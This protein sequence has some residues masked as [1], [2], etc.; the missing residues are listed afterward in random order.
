M[1]AAKAS[2]MG[3]ASAGSR[4]SSAATARSVRAS[5]SGAISPPPV[6]V[7]PEAGACSGSPLPVGERSAAVSLSGS[8]LPLGEGAASGA[9]RVASPVVRARVRWDKALD[10]PG[11]G[12]VGFAAAAVGREAQHAFILAMRFLEVEVLGDARLEHVSLV[13]LL[14]HA[15][16]VARR[17][18]LLVEGGDH[19]R[20][21][22]VH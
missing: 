12:H 16:R 10:L 7:W 9:L 14:E 15:P 3:R 4:S 1:G 5:A 21:L 20:D 8:P 6:R 11:E 2:A 22:Q 17:V 18:R 13:L 19:P